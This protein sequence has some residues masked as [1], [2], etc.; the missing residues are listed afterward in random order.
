MKKIRYKGYTWKNISGGFEPEIAV[1]AKTS[2]IITYYPNGS[3]SARISLNRGMY[4]GK[5]VTYYPTEKYL[6]K[7]ILNLVKFRA[8]K[9]LFS[10]WQIKKN[11]TSYKNN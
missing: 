7:Q 9:E 3:I 5:L 1:T 2:Q 11:A 10:G 8:S 4:H 6:R